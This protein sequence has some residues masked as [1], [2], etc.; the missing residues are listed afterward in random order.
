[1]ELTALPK[2]KLWNYKIFLQEG[3]FF[4]YKPIYTLNQ[5]KIEKLRRYI[6][7]NL[8]KRFIKLFLSPINY[9]ILFI[10]KKDRILQLY[11]NYHQ[12]ND[13]II[14]NRYT[15]PLILELINRFRKKKYYIKL[16]FHRTYNLIHIKDGEEW[17]TTF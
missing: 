6:K 17:K 2:Y 8:K 3:K 4:T 9:P 10:L 11:I 5:T 15:L 16:D 7:V 13:I 12:L 1:M 14:K